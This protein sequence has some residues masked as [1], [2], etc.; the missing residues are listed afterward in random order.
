MVAEYPNIE[1]S[2]ATS[3][4]FTVKATSADHEYVKVYFIDK[5]TEYA[6]AKLSV[7]VNGES[8]GGS[9]G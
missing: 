6:T 4:G 9:D 2:Q 7:Q 5:E 1:V 3:S 8:S